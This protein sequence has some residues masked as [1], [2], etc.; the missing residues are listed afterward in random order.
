MNYFQSL[1]KIMKQ[2]RD[3]VDGNIIRRDAK[4][5]KA[6]ADY[7]DA[8]QKQKIA[9]AEAEFEKRFN[10]RRIEALG[11][12]ADEIRSF[13]EAVK[14]KA[15]TFNPITINEVNALKNVR[16][17]PAEIKMFAEKYAADYMVLRILG[18]IADNSGYK[19]N[20]VYADTLLSIIDQT[21]SICVQFLD[22][23]NGNEHSNVTTTMICQK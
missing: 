12:V 3:E 7:K 17:T 21:E 19:L 8:F 4:I 18:E 15:S 6:N 11:V 13:K 10:E 16:L 23:Y 20:T 22:S 5:R 1:T 14:K 9:E 2:Y